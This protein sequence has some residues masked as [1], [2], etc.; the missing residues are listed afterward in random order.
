MDV[1][2]VQDAPTATNSTV[3]ATEDTT[4]TFTAGD[5]NYTDVDGEAMLQIQVTTLEGAGDL[6]YN[7]SDV[8][9]NQVI[10]KADIDAGKL[11]F[12]GAQD[13]NGTG[14]D[15]FGFKVHDGIEYSASA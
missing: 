2:A 9:L 12:K 4:Y 7:G 14:Y 15:T 1:T 6:K 11:T 5:F 8:T 10:S 3:T 13:Q